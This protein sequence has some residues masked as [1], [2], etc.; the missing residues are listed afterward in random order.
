M[1]LL[2]WL[3]RKQIQSSS[4]E[5]SVSGLPGHFG[6]VIHNEHLLFL[7]NLSFDWHELLRVRKFHKHFGFVGRAVLLYDNAPPV[8]QKLRHS[9]LAP[10]SGISPAKCA[11]G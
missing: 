4:R 7:P 5:S 1:L 10:P 6:A 3:F 9:T 8:R 2:R 11:P